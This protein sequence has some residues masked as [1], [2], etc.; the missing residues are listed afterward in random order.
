MLIEA[1][2]TKSIENPKSS[3]FLPETRTIT[4]EHDLQ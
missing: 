1:A 2:P 4:N 3:L